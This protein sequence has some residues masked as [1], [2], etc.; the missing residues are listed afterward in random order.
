[1][2]NIKKTII[3]NPE[4]F[5][6]TSGSQTRKNKD[7]QSRPLPVVSP[8]HLKT[9]LL[10]R[11]KQHKNNEI[12]ELKQKNTEVKD[13]KYTDEF[14]DA[15]GYLSDLSNKHKTQTHLQ[16]KTLK[17]YHEPTTN[18]S[19]PYV[20]L[21]LP[22][23]LQEPIIQNSNIFMHPM[24]INYKVDSVVPH[25][26]LRGGQKPTYRT[27]QKTQKHYPPINVHVE[28]SLQGQLQ[29]QSVSREERLSMIKKKLQNLETKQT[30]KQNQTISIQ[31]DPVLEEPASFSF[32]PETSL[33]SHSLSV[34]KESPLPAT[35]H[36]V[37][38]DNSNKTVIAK[39]KKYIKTTVRRKYTLGKSNVYRKVGVLVKDKNTRKN[40]LNAHKELKRTPIS[41]IKNYLRS[42]GIMKVGS[43]APNDV[44]RKTYECSRLAGEINNTN[45]D[46]LLH[47]FM[48]DSTEF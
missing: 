44:L 32:I 20:Q 45:K 29:T 38:P 40:I 31:T 48:Q 33:S 30:P 41:E 28:P 39:G 10:N 2:S 17:T 35:H 18:Y 37:E 24:N 6:F 15:I 16:N 47:N 14:Y 5:R 12:N 26:C 22:P 8:N 27:W 34:I 19:S 43:T 23:E 9:K 7:R 11:I 21:D 3:V 4:L 13:D 46:V 42:H 25:G 36:I 1:M